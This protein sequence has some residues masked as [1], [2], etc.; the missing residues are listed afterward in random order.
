MSDQKLYQ[1]KIMDHYHSSLYRGII[2]D[3]D[4]S[5]DEI[6]PSCGDRLIFD[7][8]VQNG[9]LIGLKFRGEGSILGQAIASM[10]CEYAIGKSFDEIS[11]LTKDDVLEWL[12][13]QLGPTRLRTVVFVLTTLQK[14]LKTYARQVKGS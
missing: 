13:I 11:A 9:R 10:L 4:F 12:G 8:S 1:Q 2:T 3:P 14:A 7:G 6:S 5:T